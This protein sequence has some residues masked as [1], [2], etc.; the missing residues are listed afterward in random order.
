MPICADTNM[1]LRALWLAACALPFCRALYAADASAAYEPSL[2]H[3]YARNSTGLTDAV[4]WDPHSLSI[5]GQRVY[6]LS[7]EMHPWR[8]PGDPAL[9]AD[10]LQKIRANGFNTVS[11]YLISFFRAGS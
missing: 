8:L 10:V 9:W 1:M 11:R 2:A 7:A 5:F 3:L 6:I 4:T